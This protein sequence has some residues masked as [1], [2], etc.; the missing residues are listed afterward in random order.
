MATRL[1][2]LV[3]S[4][5]GT[6]GA[7][8]SGVEQVLRQEG[9]FQWERIFGVSVGALNGVLLAQHAY[10]QLLEVWR[11]IRQ[12]DVYHKVWWPVIAWRLA[13][14]RKAGIYDG[15][16]LRKTIQK[17]A[18]GRPFR[19][20]LHVGRVSLVSGAYE[21]VTSDSPEILDAVWHSAT[22][23]V[24]WEPIGPRAL[25]DG[26]LRNVTPLGDA[27]DHHPTELIVVNCSPDQ[28]EIT[29]APKDIIE[30]AKRSLTDI[31]I[32]EIMV[33]DVREFVRIN[34]LVAQAAKHGCT[35]VSDAGKPYRHCPIGVI[36]PR[37]SLGDTLDFSRE[38]IAERFEAGKEA[39]RGFLRQSAVR[40][41][42]EAD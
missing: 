19:V 38:L 14:L 34:S 27:L 28:P 3:L 26:G 36:R 16:P 1:A 39:A 42:I 7:F 10:E 8:Q 5:G 22:M 6:K 35:L 37:L 32:N 2:T 12:E 25:V 31:T 33:N 24:I 18:A 23:P 15:S 20:P 11:T 9:G 29:S 17:H 21:R 4:G 30:A 40:S 13:V 41:P